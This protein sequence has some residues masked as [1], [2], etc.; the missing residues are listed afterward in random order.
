[1]SDNGVDINL[2]SGIPTETI[3]LLD[4]AN[5]FEVQ[6][7]LEIEFPIQNQTM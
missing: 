5:M 2:M 6:R 3:G 1:M 7:E 4:V